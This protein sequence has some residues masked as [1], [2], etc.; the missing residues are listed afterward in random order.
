M[1]LKLALCLAIPAGVL[2][3]FGSLQEWPRVFVHRDHQD[4]PHTVP[5]IDFH[6][7]FLSAFTN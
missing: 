4:L 3:G 1:V 6:H 2:D 5:P 7:F